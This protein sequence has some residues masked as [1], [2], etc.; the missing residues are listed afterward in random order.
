MIVTYIKFFNIIFKYE[1]PYIYNDKTKNNGPEKIKQENYMKLDSNK[2]IP[3][4]KCYLSSDN[5]SIKIIHLIFTRFIMEF[6]NKNYFRNIIYKDEFILNGIRVMKKYLLPSLEN[7]SCKKF[8]WILMIGNKAN[9]AYVKNLLNFNYSFEYDIIYSETVNNY[10]RNI[11]KGF[12]VLITT[13][14]DYDD[15]IYYDAVNDLRKAVNLNKPMVIYGYTRGVYYYENEN[16][17][18]DLYENF[19]NTGPMSIFHSLITVLNKVNDSYTIIDLKGHSTC[20]K[21]L[22]EKYKSFGIRELNYEPAIFDGGDAK[23]VW[24]RHKFCGLYNYTRRIQKTLKPFNFNLSNFYG[25]N[26]FK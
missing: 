10:V 13:L 2:Y 15:R 19:N 22:L 5:S 7:Q 11:T 20:R 9:R 8:K 16:K 23:F 4:E 14:I 1:K 18:Y 6:W 3:F 25:N 12:D 24:V 21:V 17:Y 26:R